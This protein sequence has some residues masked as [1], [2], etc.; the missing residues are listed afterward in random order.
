M[1]Y[2]IHQSHQRVSIHV[3]IQL[4]RADVRSFRRQFVEAI[5][6]PSGNDDSGLIREVVNG[7]SK[8]TSDASCGTDDEDTSECVDAR[9]CEIGNDLS[10]L[11]GW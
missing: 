7:K 10:R 1:E 6:T 5:L 3:D 8:R 2:T 9:H 11:V 4:H